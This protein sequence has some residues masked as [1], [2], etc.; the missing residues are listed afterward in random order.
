VGSVAV[1]ELAVVV[2]TVMLEVEL[3]AVAA[4]VAGDDVQV[5]SG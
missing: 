2:V 1:A 3:A 4:V 5:D